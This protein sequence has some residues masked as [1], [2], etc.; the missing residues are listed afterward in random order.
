MII[1]MITSHHDLIYIIDI[2]NIIQVII[3]IFMTNSRDDSSDFTGEAA[4]DTTDLLQA[5]PR[6]PSSSWMWL[7]SA[8]IHRTFHARQFTKPVARVPRVIQTTIIEVDL[9]TKFSWIQ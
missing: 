7:G 1:W 5:M 6:K 3:I 4:S 2:F 8:E 9:F